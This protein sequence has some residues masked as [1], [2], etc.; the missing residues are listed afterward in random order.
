MGK[1]SYLLFLLSVVTSNI[2]MTESYTL[3]AS[4]LNQLGYNS[5]STSIDI[6]DDNIDSID[7]NALNG[8]NNLNELTFT[9]KKLLTIDLEMFKGA[10]NLNTLRIFGQSLNKLTNL[11][12]IQLPSLTMLFLSTNF[13]SL[14]KFNVQCISSSSY[15]LD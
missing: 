9:N 4:V 5:Q 6:N 2:Y 7:P 11:K 14:S 13:T 12:N 10:V 15:L 1:L 3:T 8:F